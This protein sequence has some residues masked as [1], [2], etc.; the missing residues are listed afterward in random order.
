M[1]YS[2]VSAMDAVR[3]GDKDTLTRERETAA[4]K[5]LEHYRP[6]A[7]KEEAQTELLSV[8]VAAYNIEDYIERGLDS[9]RNQTY[10]RLEII[11]VDDGSTDETG[12]ICDRAAAADERIRVIHK[13]NGGLADARNTGMQNMT[14]RYLA[15]MDGDDWIDPDMYER[16][17][18][19]LKD[20]AAD[21]A[22]CRYRRVYRDRTDDGSVDRVVVFEGQ[23]TLEYYVRERE[24]YDIQNAAWNKLYRREIIGDITFPVGKWYEDIL[25]TTVALS[26]VQRCVYLDTAHYN[27]I[28]D[29]EGS[30][31]SAKIN[32]RTFTDHIPA[33]FEKTEF[34]KQLGRQDL[35]DI[36][37]YFIYKR[38][39]LFYN[40]LDQSDSPDDKV[41]RE[42]LTQIIQD[43]RDHY[44]RAYGCPEADPRDYAR[45]KLFLK[46]PS[47]Y[48]RR[49]RLE[50][51]IIIPLKAKIKRIL[52]I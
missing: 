15:F 52:K 27:Y 26:R 44:E 43:N 5:I 51:Q 1:V 21:A 35:A 50:E 17:L 24:E 16:M 25:F 4:M 13:E 40:Q 37:D 8:I 38:L 29:R 22:V 39:L 31:M 42:K 3:R 10:R 33:Y 7:I 48:S 32:S 47:R 12:R 23:E 6:P 46:S 34:L 14:G 11:V 49:I 28:I 36:H 45:M 2:D 18:V 41:Y 19:A 30:I 20:Q 9:I